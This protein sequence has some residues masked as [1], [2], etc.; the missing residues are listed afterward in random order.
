VTQKKTLPYS[1]RNEGK[2]NKLSG[3]GIEGALREVSQDKMGPETGGVLKTK[4]ARSAMLVILPIGVLRP[5]DGLRRSISSRRDRKGERG[6][7]G[8]ALS[9]S[10]GGETNTK[11]V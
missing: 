9:D 4:T 11:G 10:V 1:V 6:K 2:G 8:L 3:K 7:G 5:L